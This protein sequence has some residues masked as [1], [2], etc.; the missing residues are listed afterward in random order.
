MNIQLSKIKRIWVKSQFKFFA[1]NHT[2]TQQAVLKK[3]FNHHREIEISDQAKMERNT[4]RYL[5]LVITLDLILLNICL[6]GFLLVQVPYN[7]GFSPPIATDL[8][9]LIMWLNVIWL[10]MVSFTNVYQ[11]FEGVKLN[12]KIK[13]LF[14]SVLIY[15]GLISLVYYQFFF[16]VFKVH[17]LIP[18][19]T[20]F[21]LF[22]SVLHVAIRYYLGK[23]TG[24]LSYAVVG[25]GDS[26]L[27]KLQTLL[28][29]VYGDQVVC[30]GRFAPEA[31]PEVTNLGSF[32]DIEAYLNENSSISKLHY[33]YSDL[34]KQSVQRIIQ[35]CRN[36]RIDFEVVPVGVDFF[37]RGTQVEQLAHL[38][39]F[40]R[41]KEPLCQ[42]HNKILKRVFDIV[43]SL[44]VIVLIFPWLFPLLM[45]LIKL[46]SKGPI[47]F[48][49]KRTGYWNKPFYCIKFRTMKVNGKCDQE[50]AVKEDF[51]I[52]RIGSIFRKRNLD[53]LPQFF[54]VLLGDMSVV[55]PRPHMLKHTEDYSKLIDK[56]MIRHEV[57][58]GVTGWAQV[59]GWRGPT[60]ELFQMR[61]RVEY[62]VNYIENWNF[63]FDCKCIFLTI[64]NMA[65]GEEKAF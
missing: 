52:T 60:E 24:Q 29:S 14:W 34:S 12:L 44:L 55:G 58:P 25:G 49:Q 6:L 8:T 9:H 1:M 50:Q 53:E 17:F 35:L 48:F 16:P 18:A 64:F 56:Y 15:L 27:Q 33:F 32:D 3:Q 19:I 4:N 5:Y 20:T 65:R 59:S 57:K 30:A 47:F 28:T 62:D 54:N 23:K 31:I 13:D 51:R 21:L 43:F 46:E 42:F 7:N 26:N 22:S 61:K 2:M 36:R 40:R 39:I 11:V 38:P 41:K 10:L 63:W 45:L 37:E